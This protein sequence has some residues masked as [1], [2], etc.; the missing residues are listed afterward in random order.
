M[1]EARVAVECQERL[2]TILDWLNDDAVPEDREPLVALSK[3]YASV[4]AVRHGDG[5]QFTYADG[6][7][8]RVTLEGAF[9]SRTERKE[10]RV[11]RPFATIR[12]RGP[13]SHIITQTD[14]R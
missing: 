8:V 1:S 12:D 7:T 4:L 5:H 14:V 10:V 13:V 9:L 11:D 2:R 3:L 6:Q